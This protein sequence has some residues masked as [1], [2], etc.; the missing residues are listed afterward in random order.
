MQWSDG[1]NTIFCNGPDVT[2]T[3]LVEAFA[4]MSY[5]ASESGLNNFTMVTIMSPNVTQLPENVFGKIHFHN[6]VI[7]DSPKLHDIHSNAFRDTEHDVQRLEIRDTPVIVHNGGG[8]N[9]F[10][11]INSL[12][13]VEIVRIENTGLYSVPSGAFRYLPKLR[14]LSIRKGKVERVESRAFQFLPQLEHLNLD[15]NLITKIGDTAFDLDLIGNDRFHLNLDY[16]R[17]TVDSLWERPDLLARLGNRY[18]NTISLYNNS[19]TFLSEYTFKN[20][21]SRYQNSVSVI[22]DCHSCENYWLVN[23][24]LN[25]TRNEQTMTCSNQIY[26]LYQ[27]NNFDDC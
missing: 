4:K 27:P 20:F 11:A 3:S 1:S 21:L 13:N 25:R 24:G 12:K 5:A 14:E 15:H 16:N 17:L 22:L 6:I 2:D 8:H 7:A 10:H 18:N 19:I 9:V 23:S 26:G